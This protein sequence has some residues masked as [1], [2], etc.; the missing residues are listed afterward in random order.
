MPTVVHLSNLWEHTLN[1][2]LN[3]ENKSEMQIIM[4]AW[5]KYSKLQDMTTSLI[6]D[7]N[8]FT[9]SDTLYYYKEKVGSEVAIMMPTTPLKELYN[10]Y[11]YIQHLTLESKYYCDDD[12][13]DNP[14]MRKIGYCKQEE[15]I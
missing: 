13:F 10:L 6:Y 9:P 12:D 15:D 3:H 1:E 5:V 4:R 14:L 11:R 2:I 7:F 8:D